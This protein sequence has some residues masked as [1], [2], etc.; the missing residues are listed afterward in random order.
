MMEV[1]RMSIAETKIEKI[2]VLNQLLDKRAIVFFNANEKEYENQL[3]EF[4]EVNGK[5]YIIGIDLANG[6]DKTAYAPLSRHDV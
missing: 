5:P 2:K 1:K 3:D 4:I 6:S